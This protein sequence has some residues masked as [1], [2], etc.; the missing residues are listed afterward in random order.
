MKVACR[1]LR[2]P[3]R[4]NAPG[5]P[6]LALTVLAYNLVR[7]TGRIGL[8]PA[9][10]PMTV[11]TLRTRIFALPGRLTTSARQLTLHLPVGWPWQ[12]EFET[13]LTALRT[14]VLVT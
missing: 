5:L 4:S 2:G 14:V 6:D 13:I 12:H 9:T 7:W 1:V 10:P 8:G 11:K 3:R